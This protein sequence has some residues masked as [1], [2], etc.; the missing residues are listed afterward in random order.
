MKNEPDNFHIHSSLAYTAYNSI[1]AAKN[2]EIFLSGKLKED[3]IQLAHR[4]FQEAQRLRPD[5]ITN[6][7]RHGMLFGQIEGKTEKALP[8]FERAVINWDSLEPAEKE[9]RHQEKKNF[10]KALYQYA[11]AL[12]EKGR[13]K[14]SLECIKRCLSEDEKTNYI[15][16]CFKYYALG[17]IN[18][19][20][21]MYNQAKDALLFALQCDANRPEDFVCEL[22]AR[23]YLAL[24]NP[25]RALEI[26]KKVPEK[27]R[28]PYF[29]WTESDVWIALKDI[30][31][32]KKVLTEC[33]DKDARS[34][35]KTLIR[36]AKINYMLGDF[37]ASLKSAEEAG[38]FFSEKWGNVLDDAL[39]WQA[40]NSYRLGDLA[41]A[42]NHA[43]ELK[44]INSRY[45]KLRL[46]LEKLEAS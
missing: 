28:R 24:S 18:F 33:I 40:V 17:K 14:L 21:G 4:H 31:N 36:L 41:S 25:N 39:F 3:R 43:L 15:S 44:A 16:L 10:I 6:F 27:L 37:S 19:Y 22:L 46:L 45:P 11:G 32:A 2:R 13:I 20:T 9:A 38:R 30:G 26:V 12:L 1:Y 7:Y 34:K 8:L 35:H 29:R 23:T 42:L 5:G